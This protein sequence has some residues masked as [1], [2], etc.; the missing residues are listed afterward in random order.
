MAEPDCT[1]TVRADTGPEWTAPPEVRYRRWLKSGLRSYG[2]RN[3]RGPVPLSPE[4]PTVAEFAARIVAERP[5]LALGPWTEFLTKIVT[6]ALREHE[7]GR[8]VLTRPKGET[9]S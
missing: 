3:V 9:P 4:A 6:E 2:I 1:L 5:N 8:L 7:A